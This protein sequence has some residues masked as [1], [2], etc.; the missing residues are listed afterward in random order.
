MLELSPSKNS[1]FDFNSL[2]PIGLDHNRM[3][4]GGFARRFY[5]GLPFSHSDI[6]IFCFSKKAED[7]AND[8]MKRNFSDLKKKESRFATTYVPGKKTNN[9]PNC[10]AIQIIKYDEDR[11]NN[12]SWFDSFD[13]T[14]CQF[15][16]DGIKISSTIDGINDT[17]LGKIRP[18]HSIS[19]N[20]RSN[21]EFS[22]IA[23]YMSTYGYEVDHLISG[24][25]NNLLR[26]H[27]DDIRYF[28]KN[29]TTPVVS[30][31]DNTCD[32]SGY[33]TNI[34]DLSSLSFFE[35]ESSLSKE[36]IN[37][38]CFINSLQGR[39]STMM[40][41]DGI[42]YICHKNKISRWSDIQFATLTYLAELTHSFYGINTFA[43]SY[44]KIKYFTPES[45]TGTS[46]NRYIHH[47]DMDF[48]KDVGFDDTLS[49]YFKNIRYQSN[50]I[51]INIADEVNRKLDNLINTLIPI[52]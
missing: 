49:K 37:E 23:K 39:P 44:R 19:L 20:Q 32:F 26:D 2:P 51:P 15:A 7:D 48:M 14:I 36:F 30:T 21:L 50:P 31:M 29:R 34:S 38:F 28:L 40:G 16:T 42:L 33:E 1:Y 45:I 18:V 17:K 5:L 46:D 27:I 3:I 11:T 52:K 10:S 9:F 12:K 22:H 4:L 47:D 35:R 8:W 41:D 6:D 43:Y 13:M 25:H 24:S